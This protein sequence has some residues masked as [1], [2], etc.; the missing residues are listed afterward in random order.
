MADSENEK[1]ALEMRKL[2]C[3]NT[4]RHFDGGLY[5]VTDVAVHSES[6]E[7]IVIYRADGNG[8]DASGAC[9]LEMFLSNVDKEKYPGVKQ[10]KR[11]ELVADKKGRKVKAS[12]QK[13]TCEDC[14]HEY[15]CR[16]SNNLLSPSNPRKCRCFETLKDSSVYFLGYRAGKKDG[17]RG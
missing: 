2:L 3:W 5:V 1:L 16:L 11:F 4:Y 14:I 12:K 7:I 17:E 10:K 9:S 8:S 6:N 15:A 13:Y